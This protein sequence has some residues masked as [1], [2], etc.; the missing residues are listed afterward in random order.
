MPAK[1]LALA[2]YEDPVGAFVL[3]WVDDRFRLEASAHATPETA[4]L[5]F[6]PPLELSLL[7]RGDLDSVLL[8]KLRITSPMIE[9]DLSDP[10]GLSRSGKLTTEAATLR[11]ALDLTKLQ[12]FSFGGK[13]NGQVRVSRM[14][15]GQPSAEFDLNGE[16]TTGRGFS[17]TRARLAGGLRW[18]VLDLNVAE[19]EFADGSTLGGAGK[20]ELKSR[21]VTNGTWH[22]QGGQARRFL[23][24]GMSYTNLQATGHLSG[25]PGAWFHSGELTAEG[26]SAPHLKP[27]RLLARWTGD[28]LIF[29]EA[30]IKLA[31]GTSALEF[32]GA[33][34][35][36]DTASPSCDID[37]NALTLTLDAN[38]LWQLEKP[39]RV[40]VRRQAAV[41]GPGTPSAW[42]LKVE[43]FRWVGRNRELSLDG[44]VTWPWRGQMQV[45]GHGLSLSDLPEFV[46]VPVGGA[47][48]AGLDLKA[49]WEGGPIE[50]K[51]SLNG[52]VPA[53]EAETFSANIELKGDAN[54]LLADPISVSAN[55]A[56]IL[57]A[58]GKLPL[59]MIAEPGKVRVQLEENKP[60]NFQL[61]T[62]PNTR[63][64]DF[65]SQHFGVRV[66]DPKVEANLQGTLQDVRGDLHAEAAQISRSRSTNGVL[67][68]AME[69]LRVDAR[70]ERDSVRLS[71]LVF[72]IEKQPVRITGELPIRGHLLLEFISSGALPDWRRARARVEIADARI[73][74]F[75]RYLPKVLSP[76]GRLSIS[77]GVVPGGE[78][79]GE[80]KISGAATKPV[81]L[82]TPMRDIQATILFSGRRAA[83][84]QFMGRMGG[85]EVHLAGNFDFPESGEPQFDVRLRGNNVPLIYRPGLLLRSDFDVQF[86]RAGDQAVAVSGDVTLRDG[87]FLQ[88]LKALVPTGRSEPLGR[89][90]YF[91]VADKPFANWK[92]NVK[93]HGDRFLRVRTPYFRGE[94]SADFQIKG[95]LADQLRSGPLSIRHA[96][97][98]SWAGEL[99]ERPSLRTAVVRR[100]V[101]APLRLQHQNGIQR[102]GELA[103]DLLQLHSTPNI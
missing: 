65:V 78:L 102:H 84:S 89:P 11:V 7:A 88:D 5:P 85:R 77:L 54:G 81:A 95:N 64:W 98:G 57:H 22:F 48:L 96:H 39:C 101:L 68:P 34:R 92:L 74:P 51:L 30:T 21:L 37:L 58:L 59:T 86:A 79:N 50:F 72:E 44:E 70:L 71:E 100:R 23:P 67:L 76:Q 45:S 14:P 26:F 32:V 83:I 6:S 28:N 94:I 36:G 10:I 103:I 29:P 82:L 3:E 43:G 9:A 60:F 12:G 1:L 55:G 42:P 91:S 49:R 87:L 31:S 25:T 73:E 63:F 40:A 97:G 99:D 41:A 33:L 20:L 27:C 75:A 17:F 69:R 66:A 8:E 2:G 93:V 61:A 62:E 18:P 90:P 38:T 46:S 53:L 24:D 52:E 4:D 80:L 15:T 13:L 19:M 47:T 16:E 35:L 56:V